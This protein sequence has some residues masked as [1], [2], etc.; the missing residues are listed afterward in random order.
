MTINLTKYGRGLPLV[1]FHGW[2]FD[3]QIWA[4][5]IPLLTT[6]YQLI[7]VDLPGFGQSPMMGWES[8]KEEL[9]AQLPEQF[10]LVGW[11]MGGLYATRLAIEAPLRVTHLANVTSS[12]RFLSDESWPGVSKDVFVGF[13]QNLITDTRATLEEFISLHSS[14]NKVPP[15]LEHLPSSEGL[16]LGLEVLQDWDL[17]KGLKHLNI[18]VC[19]MF[20]R[21]DPIVSVKTMNVMQEQYPE[22]KYV[23]FKRAAHMPFLSHMDLFLDEIR[24]FIK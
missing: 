23:F 18:P 9:L 15:V 20:A 21:L 6:N 14:K 5:I 12:P 19:Y 22:I 8:F 3:S 1:F 17:R 11:S 24:G 2:G 4:S 7:M 13:Y 10:S 16:K